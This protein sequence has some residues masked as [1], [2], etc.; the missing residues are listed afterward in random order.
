MAL[1]ITREIASIRNRRG[2]NWLALALTKLAA[3]INGLEG[4]IGE[5]AAAAARQ[6]AASFEGPATV[7]SGVGLQLGNNGLP[8]IDVSDPGHAN[9]QIDTSWMRNT[10]PHLVVGADNTLFSYAVPSPT[11]IDFWNTAGPYPFVD[12]TQFNV[13]ANG[14][15]GNPGFKFTG[16]TA[17]TTYYFAGYADSGGNT[18]VLNAGTAAPSQTW[19]F[20]NIIKQG[21]VPLFTTWT[22]TTPASGSGGGGTGG[23]GGGGR[24][25][26]VS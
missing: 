18:H 13:L 4:R 26:P 19:L 6:R 9:K 10:I 22:I 8:I 5:V 23:G 2:D 16:L 17:N 24:Y 3:H 21:Q 25:P 7:N 15:S 14:S 12:G 11:E 1:D 20:Q